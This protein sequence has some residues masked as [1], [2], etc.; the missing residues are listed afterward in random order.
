MHLTDEQLAQFDRYRKELLDWNRRLNLTAI[1][2]PEE[3]DRLHFLDSL[4]CLLEPIPQ[5]ARLL[6]VGAGAGL[7]GL[8]LKIAR[9]D[10][11]VTLLEATGKKARFLEHVIGALEL[12]RVNVVTDRAETA[13]GRERFDVVV[14]RALAVLPALLELTLPFCRVGGK[15]LALKK[16]A[17]LQAEVASASRALQVLGA[18]LG[19]V[20]EYEL[21]GEPRQVVVIPKNSPTPAGYPRRPGMPAKRPL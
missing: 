19:E 9:Q 6:D 18:E 3:V 14:A 21:N 2:H 4:A 1:T 5:G 11:A 16:G 20:H 12:T 8:P 17:G 7:P 13:P 15:V 10:L